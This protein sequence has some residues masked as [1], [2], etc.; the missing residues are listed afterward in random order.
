[1][2]LIIVTS[3]G[4]AITNCRDLIENSID[5]PDKEVVLYFATVN[6]RETIHVRWAFPFDKLPGDIDEK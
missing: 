1:M 4:E 6:A 5:T 2:T 3:R